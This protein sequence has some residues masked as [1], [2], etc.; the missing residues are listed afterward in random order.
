[1]AAE[2]REK[3][4]GLVAGIGQRLSRASSSPKVSLEL[5]AQLQRETLCKCLWKQR[6]WG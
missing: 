5:H 6:A 2:Q 1:V 4:R 3:A